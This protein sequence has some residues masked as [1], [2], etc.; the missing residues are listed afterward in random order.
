MLEQIAARASLLFERLALQHINVLHSPTDIQAIPRLNEWASALDPQNRP[1][2]LQRFLEWDE[3]SL[4]AARQAVASEFIWPAGVPLPSWTETLRQIMAVP[5]SAELCPNPHYPFEDALL[6]FVSYFRQSLAIQAAAGFDLLSPSAIQALETGLLA[7]LTQLAAPTLYQQ[8]DA[9]RNTHPTPSPDDLVESPAKVAPRALYLEFIRTLQGEGL[10]SFFC[11]F[12]L[13]ARLLAVLTDLWIQAQSEF[14]QRLVNDQPEIERV[15]GQSGRVAAL[16]PFLSDSHNSGRTVCALEFESGLRL[17]YKPKH[18]D[19]SAA[20]HALLEWIRSQDAR[21]DLKTLR[22]LP[23]GSYGWVEFVSRQPCANQAEVQR[24]FRRMG[25]LLGVAYLLGGNDG[26]SDNIMACGEHPVFIDEESLLRPLVRLVVPE[27]LRRS[28]PHQANEWLGSSVITTGLLPWPGRGQPPHQTYDRTAMG[29]YAGQSTFP[30]T[31]GWQA[32]NTDAMRPTSSPAF[33]P[34]ANSIPF[35]Q[36]DGKEIEAPLDAQAAAAVVQGFESMA[37]FW[38]HRRADLLAADGPLAAFRG[39]VV[40]FIFRRTDLYTR[41][42]TILRHPRY[43]SDGIEF[44]LYLER[45]ARLHLTPTQKPNGWPILAA[46]RAAM[47]QFDIPFF[48][49]HTDDTTLFLDDGS[50]IPRYFTTPSLERVLAH[51]RNFDEAE[52]ARQVEVARQLLSLPQF[53]GRTAGLN[54]SLPLPFHPDASTPWSQENRTIAKSYIRRLKSQQQKHKAC[55]RRLKSVAAGR[56]GAFR[57]SDFNR[58]RLCNRPDQKNFIEVAAAL[59]CSLEQRAI[60]GED[61]GVCW[62]L[63][64]LRAEFGRFQFSPLGPDLYEG[65]AGVLLFTAALEK[66]GIAFQRLS[67]AILKAIQIDLQPETFDGVIAEIGIGGCVGIGSVLYGLARAGQMLHDPALLE[68]TSQLVNLLKPEHITAD[69]QLNLWGGAAG[70]LM[71]L[72][73]AYRATRQPAALERAVVCGQYLLDQRA[74]S[75]A[76]PRAWCMG[77]ENQFLGGFAHG[78]SGIAYAL[79]QLYAAT[80]RTDFLEAA[81]EALAY[82]TTLFTEAEHNWRDLRGVDEITASGH[83]TRRESLPFGAAWC[84]GA[85]GIGLARLEILPILDTPAIRQDIEAAL[86]ATQASLAHQDYPTDHLCCGVMGQVEFLL[87]AGLRLE[88][89]ALVETARQLAAQVVA[90]AERQGGFLYA[91]TLER[92]QFNPTFYRGAA[93]IGYELLRLADPAQV[94]SVLMFE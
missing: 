23:C 37:R 51:L 52:L 90:R 44:S 77:L 18:L 68:Q 89:P 64:R 28:A 41:L 54:D 30:N 48:S 85:V 84:D 46:E 47:Q 82:E 50:P 6:P 71:G 1:E 91:T 43:L 59:G 72:L 86:L 80:Q 42:Q 10:V 11:A 53:L 63:P 24:Y 87:T 22:V 13:L 70:V 55:L 49:S 5:A 36:L 33:S 73:A 45:L 56:L 69:R 4:D 40:R 9:F 31:S 17:V 34:T 20:Y 57:R 65:L 25:L 14:L 58:Q 83:Y 94:P 2:T 27:A 12:P 26:H 60:W 88:R 38:L 92:G 78:T 7:R 66:S 19:V 29:A 61:G 3:I 93:G 74:A 16:L 81:Q 35:L 21:L 67:L 15:F 75:P 79:A 8:F 76:G 39:L 62:L 32:L